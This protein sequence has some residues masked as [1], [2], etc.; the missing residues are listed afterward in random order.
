MLMSRAFTLIE[1]LIVV[2]IIAILAVI[3]VPNFLEAQTRSKVS[4]VRADHFALATALE[5]YRVDENAYPSAESNGTNK[6]LRWITTPVAYIASVNLEDPFT[7]ATADP[8]DLATLVSYRYYRYYGFNE[9][10]YVNARSAT[11]EVLAVYGTPGDLKVKFF[12]LFSHGPDRVRSLTAD[13]KTFL[14]Q[15]ILLNPNRFTELIYDP[16]NGTTSN[17]EIFRAGGSPIGRAAPAM[18][19]IQRSGSL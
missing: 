1:L 19:L 5:A 8:D 17:G 7:G 16:T 4:R 6:W 9:M 18:Q 2:A 3:A 13:G 12:V 10:G 11:G 14:Q 15:D